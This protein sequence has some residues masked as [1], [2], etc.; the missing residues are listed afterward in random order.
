MN[1]LDDELRTLLRRKEPPEGF[2]ERVLARMEVAASRPDAI[3][4]PRRTPFRRSWIA[5]AAGV[6]ACLI[7]AISFVRYRRYQHQRAEAELASQ[8]ATIALRI[9]STQL[10]RALQQAQQVTQQALAG[11]SKKEMERL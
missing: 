4:L 8:Q 7:L 2:A 5:W 3:R 6:A 11:K 1:W 10:N 9:A